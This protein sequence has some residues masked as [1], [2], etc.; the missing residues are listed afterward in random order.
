MVA[1][2]MLPHAEFGPMTIG[3]AHPALEMTPKD[4]LPEI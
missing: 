4:F 3:N 1:V 2:P